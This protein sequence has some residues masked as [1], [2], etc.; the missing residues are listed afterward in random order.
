MT[1]T[2]PTMAMINVH[3]IMTFENGPQAC[4]DAM[5]TVPIAEN[6]VIAFEEIETDVAE[7]IISQTP[8][9]NDLSELVK[10]SLCYTG[11]TGL[12]GQDLDKDTAEK[13][14]NLIEFL[15]RHNAKYYFQPDQ[16][17]DYEQRIV[18]R[19]GVASETQNIGELS[20]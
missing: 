3:V 4:F 7:Q 20:L 13:V 6:D 8:D 14:D 17:D 19:T 5:A 18:D 16:R 9:G 11:R 1:V 2:T 10:I 15:V 12:S